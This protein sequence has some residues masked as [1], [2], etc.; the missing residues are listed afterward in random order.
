[1]S[2]ISRRWSI[3]IATVIFLAFVGYVEYAFR[4]AELLRPWAA[5]P[6]HYVAAAASLVMVSY[7]I[8][9][10]RLFHYFLGEM[11]GRYGLCLR[12]FLQHNLLNILLPMRSGELSFPLLMGRYFNIPARRSVPVLLWFRMLD[13]H[14]LLMLG[15]MVVLRDR[16]PQYWYWGLWLA[17]FPYLAY[18]FSHAASRFVEKR[19]GTRMMDLAADLLASL[20]RA[21]G[22]F[23]YTWLW[24]WLNWMVKLLVFAWVFQLFLAVPVTQ[25]WLAAI[26]GDLTSVL[27]VHGLAGA[28]TYEAGIVAALLPFGVA[29]EST[30][31]AAVNLHLFLLGTAIL[32]GLASVALPR[33]P[34]EASA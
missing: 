30:L 16:Y 23:W 20:P 25:A 26:A 1:M 6:P 34:A 8:R 14:T 31:P 5:L 15:L 3:F 4:W 21:A 22:A 27:P 12:L 33:R 13:L 29:A 7:G 17:P 19:R 32:A 18:R 11:R 24:T 28:G 2:W 9:A 10:L